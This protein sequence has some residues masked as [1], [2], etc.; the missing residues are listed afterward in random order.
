MR[1]LTGKLDKSA[2]MLSCRLF[3]RDVRSD[4][5]RVT[6]LEKGKCVCV[7]VFSSIA[8]FLW[9][10]TNTTTT[11]TTTIATVVLSLRVLCLHTVLYTHSARNTTVISTFPH[12]TLNHH[13]FCDCPLQVL[14][15]SLTLLAGLLTRH[16][17]RRV[18]SRPP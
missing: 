3:L 9:Y 7:C 17:L 12:R 18:C 5:V 6:M 8:I 2:Q 1:R 11:T 4:C 13:P 14:P 10:V 15:A 16:L